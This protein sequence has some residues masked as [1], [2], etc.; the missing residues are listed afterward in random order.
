MYELFTQGWLHTLQLQPKWV[1]NMFSFRLGKRRKEGREE[2]WNLNP[3]FGMDTQ[4][5]TDVIQQVFHDHDHHS[6]YQ[7][8]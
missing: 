7:V 4:K 6:C 3:G 1:V 8:G 2:M 5:A